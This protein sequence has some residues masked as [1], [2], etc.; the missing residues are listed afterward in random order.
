MN[1]LGTMKSDEIKFHANRSKPNGEGV[2]E[3]LRLPMEATV[4][5][6]DQEKTRVCFAVPGGLKE[7]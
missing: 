2:M 5:G 1:L 4:L 6:S 7:D 3:Q